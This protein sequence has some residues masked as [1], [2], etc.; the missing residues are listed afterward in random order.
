[1]LDKVQHI[2]SAVESDLSEV[3]NFIFNLSVHE[4]EGL[5]FSRVSAFENVADDKQISILEGIRKEFE[6]PEHINNSYDTVPS[7]RLKAA[8]P[9]YQKVIDGTRVA[10]QTGIDRIAAECR[11][12]ANWL[13]KLTAWAKEGQS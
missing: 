12:F 3:N 8:I 13:A 7:R 10:Q 6:T 2:E 9:T 5:L 4:Y 11:H 1:L